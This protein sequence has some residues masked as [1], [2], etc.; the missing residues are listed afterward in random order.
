MIISPV[1]LSVGSLGEHGSY[2]SVE[3]VF[4]KNC[5]FYGAQNGVRIKTWPVTIHFQ[6]NLDNLYRK[7]NLPSFYFH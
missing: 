7:E 3:K 4:V 2:A 1:F 6:G 5:K